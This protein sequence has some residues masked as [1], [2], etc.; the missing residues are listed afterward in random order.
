MTPTAHALIGF[1]CWFVVLTLALAFLRIYIT[2][3]TGKAL[4]SFEPDGSDTP[5]IGRRFTRARD[6]CFETLGLFAAIV[7]GAQLSGRVE[8]L[9]GLA[10]LVLYSRMVQSVTHIASTSV[11][12]VLL[13]ATMFVVQLL[14]YLYWTVKL[15]G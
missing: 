7:L 9:D 3:T 12:A 13:R 11:P 10:P 5:G 14:I 2:A 8:M 1:A 6:N 4:N 15:L